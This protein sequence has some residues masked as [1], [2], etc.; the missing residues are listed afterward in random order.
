[1]FPQ[2]NDCGRTAFVG[3]APRKAAWRRMCASMSMLGTYSFSR[4]VEAPTVQNRRRVVDNTENRERNVV[5]SCTLLFFRR[6]E[7]APYA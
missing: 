3:V 2:S 4:S 1:M 5:I 7:N 6:H